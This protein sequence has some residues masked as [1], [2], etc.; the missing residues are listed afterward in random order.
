MIITTLLIHQ[1]YPA[2]TMPLT[3]L[4]HTCQVAVAATRPTA[5]RDFIL[6]V[7]SEAKRW[8]QIRH[9]NVTLIINY[10]YTVLL[11]LPI[12]NYDYTQYHT[13]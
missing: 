4:I 13:H 12:Y 10:D 1:S 8:V 9:S 5:P 3:T 11:V 6:R 2:E 7:R